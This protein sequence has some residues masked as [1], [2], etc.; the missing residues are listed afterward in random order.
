[1]VPMPAGSA[2]KPMLLTLVDVDDSDDWRKVAL[3]WL[4]ISGKDREQAFLSQW[5]QG[6]AI[7]IMMER[8][9]ASDPDLKKQLIADD[10]V[11]NPG[12]YEG[13][14]DPLAGVLKGEPS[15]TVKD[16]L[17]EFNGAQQAAAAGTALSFPEDMRQL[18]LKQFG[19][20]IKYIPDLQLKRLV[21]GYLVGTS[22]VAHGKLH[23]F[24]GEFSTRY[25]LGDSVNTE[26]LMFTLDPE[27]VAQWLSK[28]RNKKIDAAKLKR[29]LLNPGTKPGP[30]SVYSDARILLH[31]ISHLLMRNS[32]IYS[33]ISRDSLSEKIFTPRLAFMIY[34]QEGSE[35]GALRTTFES[36]FV[37]LSWLA[38]ARNLA[39]KCPHGDVCLQRNGACHACLYVAER[40][41]T[42]L[43]NEQ[44]DRRYVVTSGHTGK[45]YWDG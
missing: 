3:E 27:R 8:K 42:S 22:D 2:I 41:C 33:G 45:G 5:E 11:K 37:F 25:V 6:S 1:M 36:R 17:R 18:V 21:Y 26:A 23:L 29:T 19:L 9:I 44:L 34:S 12:R 4:G 28:A 7:R 40:C 24:E 20:E 35:L 31:T 39:D 16:L 15:E 13:V 10:I 30:G 43:W 32:E 38:A 14:G